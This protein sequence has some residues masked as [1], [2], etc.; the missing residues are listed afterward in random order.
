[1]RSRLDKLTFPGEIVKYQLEVEHF[2]AVVKQLQS[3]K[4]ILALCKAGYPLN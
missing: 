2:Q 4:H 1:M 3:N